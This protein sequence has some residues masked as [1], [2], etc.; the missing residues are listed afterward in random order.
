MKGAVIFMN[1]EATLAERWQWD[2]EEGVMKHEYLAVRCGAFRLSDTAINLENEGDFESYDFFDLDDNYVTTILANNIGVVLSGM[3]IYFLDS[4]NRN[5]AFQKIYAH[6]HNRLEEA[7]R[8]VKNFSD[9]TNDIA[10]AL[11][12]Q[13][14]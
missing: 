9:I 6:C 14:P 1:E 3:S 5:E 7:I 11:V 2:I 4:G 10:N 13:M 8:D 12:L